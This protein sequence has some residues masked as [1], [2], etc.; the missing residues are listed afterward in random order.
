MFHTEIFR[1]PRRGEA[2]RIAVFSYRYDAHLVPGLIKNIRPAVHGYVAWD[3]RGSA[4]ALS[5]EPMRRNR[6]ILEAQKLGAAWLLACDPDERFEDRLARRL[7]EM[8]AEGEGTL[9][10]VAMR[11]MFDATHYRTDGIWG[12]K[13][14][15]RFF[16]VSAVGEDLTVPLH[17]AWVTDAERFRTAASGLNVY[18]MRM[19]SPVRRRLRRALY[20]AADPDRQY[21]RPGYDYLDDERGMRLEPIPEG[22]GYSPPFVEDHGLW[23]PDPGRIGQ[24]MPDPPAVRLHFAKRSIER[25]GHAAAF[26]ALQDLCRAAPQDA[27]LAHACARRALVAGDP[28]AALELTV[29]LVRGGKADLHAH[30]LHALAAARCG[31][32][33]LAEASL[34]VLAGG[35]AGSPVLDWLATACCRATVDFAAPDALWRRWVSGRARLSEGAGL[36]RGAR[37]SVIV[38]GYQAQPGLAAAVRSLLDQDE[39]A[40]I[41]VVNSGGGDAAAVLGPLAAAVRLIQVEAPLYVGAARNIGVDASRA[42]YVAF[43]AGDCTAAPGW[44]SG[45]MRRHLAGA[46]S[47]STPV[48][49]AETDSLAGI[50]AHYLHYWGR[51]P[52]TPDVQRMHFGRSFARWLLEEAGAFPPGLRV[53][54][55][56]VLNHRADHIGLPVWAPE[57]LTAHRDPAMLGDLLADERARGMRRADHPPF[58]GWV[59]SDKAEAEFSARIA[60]ACGHAQSAAAR[61]GGLSPRRLAAVQAMQWLATQAGAAGAIDA[62]ERLYEAD[63]AAARAEALRPFSPAAALTEALA[64]VTADPQDWRKA[65]LAGL[66]TVE[67]E[68]GDPAPYFRSAM[69]LNPATSG[70]VA[71]LVR[72]HRARGNDAAAL[73]EAEAALLRAPGA[74]ALWALAGAAAEQAGKPDR[75]LAWRRGALALAPDDPKAH[76]ALARLHRQGG[77]D[78]LASLREDMAA[79]LQARAPVEFDS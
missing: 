27:D 63:V 35:L 69:A 74:G 46:L 72:L 14:V 56:G 32:A 28:Q 43:L 57:V 79:D 65:Y 41:V 44:V 58:R 71:E 20:A 45:R 78:A 31:R 7:P 54:E 12:A 9:W 25:G 2:R 48:L 24:V 60:T 70:P 77:N 75:A 11:E 49:P 10:T 66:L 18:H 5:D 36:A 52:E 16:S 37:M 29:P 4:A 22:R 61:W 8:A 64:A 3:D 33:D 6:L 19:A 39:A 76:L 55:D 15:M 1:S 30:L 23:A 59:G 51:H 47:V 50:A 62:L 68:T 21:Q 26:H 67:A 73:A 42:E 40:E 53:N 13:A 38:L 17:A 34:A